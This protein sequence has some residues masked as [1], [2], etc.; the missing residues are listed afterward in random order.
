VFDQARI[1][2]DVPPDFGMSNKV[3][4]VV[5]VKPSDKHEISP[6]VSISDEDKAFNLGAGIVYT[7]RNFF[8]GARIFTTRLR[9]R[10]QTILAFPEYFKTNSDAVS[11]LDLSFEILQPYVFS[12][13]YKGHWTFSLILDKQELYRQQILKNVFGITA[14]LAQ[15]TTGTLDWTLQR[16][17]LRRNTSVVLDTTDP[18]IKAQYDDLLIQEMQTQFNSILSFT[19][20]RDRTN[21]IFSPSAGFA[22]SATIEESGV[23]P[24]ILKQDLPF[25]QFYRLLLLGRWFHDPSHERLW[26][27]AMKLKGGIE[28]KYGQSRSD[29]T[30]TIPQTHRF[31]G[32]GGGSVRGWN[33]RELSASGVPDLGG[34]LALEGSL[35]LR[36]NILRSLRNEILGHIWFVTFL[37]AGNVWAEVND[38]QVKGIAM[39]TGFGLRYDSFFGPFRID[40]GFRVYD[41]GAPENQWITE[42]RFFGDTVSKGVIHFG[43]GHAF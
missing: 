24:V 25:T 15:Y 33:S 31:Y 18:A 8:G 13:K 21:D 39:A 5:T 37:D 42:R 16:V 1:T 20:V 7:Q 28:E 19:V 12:N 29:T 32:G 34:N 17:R 26:I 40:F 14:R 30:R 27:V 36:T 11:N 23:L 41:P 10:T 6:E 2:V 38:F 9:F 35:E 4:S 3:T 22:H 43:I